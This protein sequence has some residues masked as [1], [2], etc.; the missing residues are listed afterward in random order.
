VKS[1]ASKLINRELSWLEFNQRVLDEAM[2]PS[3][4]LLDQLKFLA[5]TCSN[6]D[7]FFMVRVGG[8]QMLSDQRN[9]KPD[10][11]GMTPEEQLEAICRRTHKMVEDQYGFFLDRLEPALASAGIRRVAPGELS[12]RHSRYLIQVFESEIYSVLTPMAVS[13]A[14]EF[15]L[16]ANRMLHVCVRMKS[17]AE[18]TL[19]PRFAIIPLGRLVNRFVTL[20]SDRGY[21]Y[22]LLE[23][24]VHLFTDVF[25]P[26]QQVIECIP[27]R[28]TRNADMSVREDMAA[29]LL[30]EMEE[31]LD[32]RKTGEAV[33]LEIAEAAS[34]SMLSFLQEAL[35]V[36]DRDI[37]C[38]PGPLEFSAFMPLTDL[39]G[40]D[41]LRYPAWPPQGSPGVDLRSSMF[42]TLSAGDVLLCHPFE[43]FEPVGKLISEAADDPDVLA[44]KQILYRTS[45][46]SPMVDALRRAALKGKYVTAIVELKARFDEARNI[47]WARALEQD[48]VQV[49]Y[50]V[51][52]LK[53]HAKVCIVV[54]REPEGIKR[55]VHFGTGNY[56]EVTSRL[57]TD[58]SFM[59]TNPD[60]GADAVAFFNAITGF[61]QPQGYRKIAAAPTNLRDR[62]LEL[63]A[64]ETERRRQ[65]QQAKIMAKLN[66]LADP[67]VIQAL[68]DAS[69]AGVSIQLNVRGICCLRPGIKG[70][71]E[72]IRVVSI[73]DRFLEHSRILYVYAGGEERVFISSADWMP[74][75]L[76]RRVELLVPVEDEGCKQRLVD[77]LQTCLAD[78]VKARLLHGDGHYE[79]VQ[80]G[81]GQDEVRS[82]QHLYRRAKEA[83]KEAR[84]SKR[85]MFEPYKPT[86]SHA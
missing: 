37:Y 11:S 5:I 19:R 24:V 29:D 83:E 31:V 71:S 4:P 17:D 36:R 59:T 47:E 74:R 77:I 65:G 45:R 27:F 68:Y 56:N 15:P 40:F 85:T 32:A 16:L 35:G 52:G 55:Y 41:S 44:I 8:L 34:Q 26:G 84:Q 14:E 60:L 69:A 10:P 21:E 76:D 25:F 49:I 18:E 75:N 9:T 70:L 79:P 63:I 80:A 1:A 33:R 2:D 3:V 43:S 54:R 86:T 42:G 20:P 73:V 39:Q 72:N 13:S 67:L 7:E 78:N 57:Y 61:S 64:S 81:H 23:D 38:V 50:G 48:G 66:S 30:A 6:L 62:L 58:V 46:N 12:D 22:I 82:Q 53:T 28:M 51:K